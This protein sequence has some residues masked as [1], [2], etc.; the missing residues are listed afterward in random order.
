MQQR[1]SDILRTDARLSFRVEPI[2]YRTLVIRKRIQL[3]NLCRLVRYTQAGTSSKSPQFFALHVETLA[4]VCDTFGSEALRIMEAC[5]SLQT[6]VF[7]YEFFDYETFEVF[8]NIAPD[9][10]S[11][12]RLSPRRLSIRTASYPPSELQ[13]DSDLRFSDA[14]THLDLSWNGDFVVPEKTEALRHLT[15]LA[16]SPEAWSP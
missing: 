6:L 14:V 3:S 1:Y 5:R 12:L 10:L 11:S 16:I 2:L 8:I 9:N 4:I 7:W 15:H 13:L